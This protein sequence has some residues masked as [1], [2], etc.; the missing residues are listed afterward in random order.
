MSNEVV[1]LF[2]QNYHLIRE[3]SF[4]VFRREQSQLLSPELV[5]I[6]SDK[7]GTLRYQGIDGFFE[8]MIAWSRHF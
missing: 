5:T 2:F 1:R 3:E 6:A 4:E 7:R 8:G